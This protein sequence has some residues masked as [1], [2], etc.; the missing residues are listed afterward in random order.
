MVIAV[1]VICSAIV[2]TGVGVG[3]GIFL[4]PLLSLVLPPKTAL[5]LG[6]PS[7]LISDVTGL[8]LYWREWNKKE[9][10]LII[11]PALLGVFFG[12]IV[13][14]LIPSDIFKF[15]IGIFALTVA[16]QGFFRENISG[17]LNSLTRKYTMGD[18]TAITFGFLGGLVSTI[19]HAGGA[20]I[21]IYLLGKQS[22]KREFVSLFILFFV[23][24]NTAKMMGYISIK[25]LTPDLILLAIILSPGI[26]FGSYFG[27]VLNKKIPQE[28]FRTVVLGIIFITGLKLLLS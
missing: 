6:A 15:G 5:A 12:T 13:I 21:S 17:L 14:D 28:V 23:I 18:K 24:T 22:K 19:S 10:I 16:L 11:P 3:A 25:I 4:L 2:K 7:M 20:V 27:N 1:A 26:I 9:A 8:K